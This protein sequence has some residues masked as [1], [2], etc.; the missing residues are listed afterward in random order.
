MNHQGH[1]HWDHEVHARPPTIANQ[2][3][4]GAGQRT[5][6]CRRKSPQPAPRGRERHKVMQT[7]TGQVL[8][9]S[10]RG[11]NTV[12]MP[13]DRTQAN[14]GVGKIPKPISA[15]LW[16]THAR[17][18]GKVL[19]RMASGQTGVKLLIQENDRPQYLMVYTD[20]SV[21]KDQSGWS[22]TV[23][24]GAT[25]IHW[26]RQCGLYGLNLYFGNGSGSSHPCPP[27][28][29]LKRRQSDHACHHRHRFNE[30]ATESD[31]GMGS[32]DWNV[33]MVDIHLRQ[34]PWV[35]CP[36]HAGVKGNDRAD[37]W[38]AKQPS[39]VACFS[40]DQKCW[41]AWDTTCGHKAKDITPSIA[42]RRKARKEEALDD[43]PWKDERR[44]SSI[45]RTMEPF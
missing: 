9:E 28:D 8:D 43:A 15:S 18:H 42:W 19:S 37:S 45:R 12:S 38:R 44:L 17:K 13:A 7:G 36:G 39:Q 3:G 16:D 24:Q 10:N 22:F 41:G 32:P 6:Q 4:S 34:L 31:S 1:T 25:T 5:L 30:L 20:G 26:W 11:L 2:T 40:E 35:Y 27:L 21:T 14:Q 29:C 33:S 23:K